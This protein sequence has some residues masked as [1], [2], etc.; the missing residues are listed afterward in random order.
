MDPS[1]AKG[2]WE[3]VEADHVKNKRAMLAWLRET[4]GHVGMVACYT[5]IAR[6][7]L[8]RSSKR[9][10]LL[11]YEKEVRERGKEIRKENIEFLETLQCLGCPGFFDMM[12]D[13]SEDEIYRIDR[14]TEKSNVTTQAFYH[15]IFL[16]HFVFFGGR[17]RYYLSLHYLHNGDKELYKFYRDLAIL[18]RDP[19][20]CYNAFLDDDLSYGVRF[21]CLLLAAKRGRTKALADLVELHGDGLLLAFA[22][23][24]GYRK[25]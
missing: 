5:E 6:T 13:L 8:R 23:K 20:A 11:L 18:W 21:N 25:E 17:S 22:S 3:D 14:G 16:E 24:W 4:I 15:L 7:A 19:C 1:A 2:V 9:G 10:T 12:R